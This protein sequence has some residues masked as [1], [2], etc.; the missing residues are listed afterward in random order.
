[1]ASASVAQVHRAR[2]KS[3]EKVAVKVLRPGIQKVIGHDVQI[4]DLIASLIEHLWFDG[5][6]LKPREV[7]AEFAKHLDD[8][9][10]LIREASNCSQLRR[11]FR[12]SALLAVP[13]VHWDY[14]T[15]EVMVF[16]VVLVDF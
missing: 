4:L 5:K 3:G 1:M 12:D 13:A 6:R 9:L 11:N 15:P 10:D 7:V 8:E 14:C 2:L 16:G